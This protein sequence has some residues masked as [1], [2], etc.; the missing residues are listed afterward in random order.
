VFALQD[1]ELGLVL[2]ALGERLELEPMAELHE[3]TDQ[4]RR[5]L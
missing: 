4:G 3:R 1:L 5:L 2:D